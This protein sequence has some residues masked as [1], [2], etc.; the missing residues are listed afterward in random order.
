M[1]LVTLD[2]ALKSKQNV[3]S[4]GL[5]KVYMIA[6]EYTD[7]ERIRCIRSVSDVCDNLY[8]NLTV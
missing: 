8:L 3:F 2:S 4:F 5:E 1:N 6:E 7:V